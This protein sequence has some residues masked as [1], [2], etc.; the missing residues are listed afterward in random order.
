MTLTVGSSIAFEAAAPEGRMV[1]HSSLQSRL[2]ADCR[3]SGSRADGSSQSLKVKTGRT[4]LRRRGDQG[5]CFHTHSLVRVL[6]GERAGERAG[7]GLSRAVQCSRRASGVG[8]VE[9]AARA[10]AEADWRC[11]CCLR[12]I[13]GRSGRWGWRRWQRPGRS[14]TLRGPGPRPRPSGEAARL[15]IQNRPI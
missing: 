9:A 1:S 14:S 10:A 6:P 11:R 8:S 13:W 12:P 7:C 4:E 5:L 15:G 2:T 3:S